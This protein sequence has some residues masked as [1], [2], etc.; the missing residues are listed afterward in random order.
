MEKQKFSIP[1][2]RSGFACRNIEVEATSQ[3]EAENLA[4]DEAGNYEFSE[5][6]SEYD[7][8]GGFVPLKEKDLVDIH[9]KIT[10]A[11]LNQVG[12]G[13]STEKLILLKQI[14]NIFKTKGVDL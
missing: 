14:K 6:T 3:E 2:I 1:V 12:G 9:N 7:I 5:H 8:D 4:L 11:V 13:E 10:Q